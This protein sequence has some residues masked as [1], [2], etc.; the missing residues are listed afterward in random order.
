[1]KTYLL[2]WNPNRYNWE[3]L[4]QLVEEVKEGKDVTLRWSCGRSKSIRKGDRFYLIRLGKFPKG[5][6]ASGNVIKEP[7]LDVSWKGKPSDK[8]TLYVEVL[9]DKLLNPE[10]DAI[11]PIEVLQQPPLAEMHWYTQVSGIKIRDDIITELEKL[12][13]NFSNHGFYFADEL[14][15]D[16]EYLEGSVKSVLVNAYERNVAARQ[17]CISYFG[18][19]CYICG[20]DFEKVYG[21]IGKC[22]IHVHHIVPIS[23]IGTEYRIDPIKD[24]RPVCP[25]CHS[26]IH[27]R[28]PPF[29]VEELVKIVRAK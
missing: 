8:P 3:E 17:K 1:M 24:L 13:G 6:F 5:I 21:E 27:R 7:F 12:W 20:F 29:T 25:N 11:L 26:M 19:S 10:R 9:F 2:A 23:E 22:Y 14:G 28:K 4:P 16:N 18:T 15:V